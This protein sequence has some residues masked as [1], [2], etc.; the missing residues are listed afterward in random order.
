MDQRTGSRRPKGRIVLA[1]AATALVL[2]ASGAV[3]EP[4]SLTAA[5]RQC[6]G[7]GGR[8]E[9][10][11]QP[12]G[13]QGYGCFTDEPFTVG[14]LRAAQNL[15]EHRYEGVFFTATPPGFPSIAFVCSSIE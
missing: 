12:E 9:T 5:Q 6:Q 4:Q 7:F 14:Q 8:F 11:E 10:A 1:L 3:A 2:G 15:C 13:A